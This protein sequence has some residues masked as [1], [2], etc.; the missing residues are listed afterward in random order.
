[1]R[2]SARSTG[3]SP[4]CRSSNRAVR[5]A[6]SRRRH[7]S[8]DLRLRGRT[9]VRRTHDGQAG[10]LYRRAVDASA[11]RFAAGQ[12]IRCIS[13]VVVAAAFR[14]GWTPPSAWRSTGNRDLAAARAT[15]GEMQELAAASEGGRYPNLDLEASAGRQ[16]YGA[17]FLGPQKL[18]P[19]SFYSVGFGGQLRVRLR[20]RRAPRRSSSSMRWPNISSMRSRPRRSAVSGNVAMQ[21]LAAA[22]A[23]AQIESARGTAAG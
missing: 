7:R 6:L 3:W 11:G 13:A 16:K 4:E 10:E 17:A 8:N 15:L 22:S 20:R 18:P 19:F 21:A 2:T 9:Q 12:R 14:R 1:M 5:T 23:R